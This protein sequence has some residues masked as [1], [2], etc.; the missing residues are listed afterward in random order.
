[1]GSDINTGIFICLTI[2]MVVLGFV[3]PLVC[4]V[5][6]DTGHS[7]NVNN[8][9]NNKGGMGLLDFVT[10]MLTAL[11][12]YWGALPVYIGLIKIIITIAWWFCLVRIIW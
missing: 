1:M 11:F 2:L 9:D 6:G 4:E 10:L 12:W 5:V 3:M 7:N 8:I